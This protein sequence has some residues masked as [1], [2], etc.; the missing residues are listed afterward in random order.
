MYLSKVKFSQINFPKPI[1]PKPIFPKPIFP[2]RIFQNV[3]FQTVFFPNCFFFMGYFLNYIFARCTPPRHLPSFASLFP[4]LLLCLHLKGN[5][6]YNLNQQNFLKSLNLV[7][8]FGVTFWWSRLC[9]PNSP[10]QLWTS[11]KTIPKYKQESPRTQ[12]A[13]N[14]FSR[15]FMLFFRFQFLSGNKGSL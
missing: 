15:P 5:S 9:S 4:Y 13:Y 12:V 1:F 2:K 7:L 14:A 3:F 11:N 6:E 8:F 10:T